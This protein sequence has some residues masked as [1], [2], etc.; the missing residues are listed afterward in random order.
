MPLLS[1]KAIP[2]H[3][4]LIVA[5]DTKSVAEAQELVML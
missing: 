5:L 1:N 4:R 2:V 3:E